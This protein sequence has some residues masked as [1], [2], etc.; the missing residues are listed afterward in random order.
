M[1]N[2]AGVL[3]LTSRCGAKA[4]CELMPAL[5]R[6]H[7]IHQACSGVTGATRACADTG[8]I[9]GSGAVGQRHANILELV[10][11][12]VGRMGGVVLNLEDADHVI[13]QIAVLIE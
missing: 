8:H 11:N 13:A 5:C 2:A 10:H 3:Q 4:W 1:V 7:T 9:L 6:G 12:V